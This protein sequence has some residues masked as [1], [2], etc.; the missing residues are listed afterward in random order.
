MP[1][2]QLVVDEGAHTMDGLLL[3]ARDGSTPVEAFISRRVMDIWIE[4]KEPRGR[5]KSAYRAQYNAIGKLNLKAIGRVVDSKYRG[6]LDL[7]RQH[8]FVDI[9]FADIVK[10]GET[11]DLGDCLTDAMR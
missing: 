5:R 4:P 8:P 10:S 2:T 1:L 3:H 7:N 6:G 9:L 11:L